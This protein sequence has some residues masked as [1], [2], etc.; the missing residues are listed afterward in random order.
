[1]SYGLSICSDFVLPELP[2]CQADAADIR[3]RLA[4]VPERLSS[5]QFEAA[6][7]QATP[8]SYLL[9]VPG[10]ARYLV[11][12][13][14]RIDIEPERPDAPL[15]QF[16]YTSPM[17]ALLAQRSMTVLQGSAV[18]TPRGA[19]I[20]VG[21]PG[22]GRSVVSAALHRAGYPLVAEDLC[23]IDTSVS[24]LLPGPRYHWLRGRDIRTLDLS[25]H[26]E[27]LRSG[28]DRQ[29]VSLPGASPD[30][31]PIHAVC[32]LDAWNDPAISVV[33]LNSAA[34]TFSLLGN[35]SLRPITNR[36]DDP[37]DNLRRVAGLSRLTFMKANCPRKDRSL[38]DTV[39]A[40]VEALEL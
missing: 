25:E 40:L 29:F 4:G 28:V 24:S 8:D 2:A 23:V 37:K 7:C 33:P 26:A 30:P 38:D 1:M 16:L 32:V 31:V 17:A 6:F 34:R 35:L 14:C 9:H 19:V 36:F 27:H 15:R 20:F 5:P 12:D 13:G 3:V 11:E 39:Q 18:Q 21:Q 22:S 10:V